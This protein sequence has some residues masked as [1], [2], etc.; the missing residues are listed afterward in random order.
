MKFPILVLV[1]AV[2]V[3]NVDNA[4][5]ILAKSAQF[6][7]LDARVSTEPSDESQ[8]LSWM[9]VHDRQS[10]LLGLTFATVPAARLYGLC[11]LK[12]LRA[13]TYSKTRRRLAHDRSQVLLLGGCIARHTTVSD[14]LVLR[15]GGDRP[16]SFD[17]IC[18]ALGEK[19]G[20]F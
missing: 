15:S 7:N 2:G 8:A 12:H 19:F 16:P 6:A 9:I 20:G 14:A 3:T 11:G 10:D 4:R 1:A 13:A 18:D 17:E 5:E